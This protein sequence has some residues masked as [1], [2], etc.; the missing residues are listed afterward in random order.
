VRLGSRDTGRILAR[1]RQSVV[2]FA[3]GC[4]VDSAPPEAVQ[5]ST[6][7]AR[8]SRVLSASPTPGRRVAFS[9]DGA[10]LAAS[11]A[12]GSIE[13]WRIPEQRLARTLTDSGGVTAVAFSPDGQWLASASYDHA[14]RV[15]RVADGLLMQTL[16]GHEG[17]VWAVAVSPDGERIASSGEDRT[18]RLWRASD[19]ASLAVLRG[20]TLNV[21]SV[22]FTPD[23]AHIVSG[24]FDHSVRIWDARSGAL[25]QTLRGHDEAVVDVAVSPNAQLVASG[26]DDEAI[27]LWRLRDGALLRTLR[28]G[29]NHVWSVTFSRDGEW[30]ASAGRERGAFGSFWTELVGARF[31]SLKGGDGYSVRLWRVRDGALVQA[32]ATGS[33]VTSVAFSPD[34]QWLA[35]SNEDG[36]LKLWRLEHDAG[37]SDR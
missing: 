19:G 15:W 32:L 25:Q 30:L 29:T 16:R 36:A 28:G 9:Q 1:V 18:I 3:M 5:G 2:V 21:W 12:G 14:V 27:R 10:L 17:T 11:N 26:G 33:D 8:L 13:L 37:A 35:T 34:G 6:I 22:A 24:S 20:H 4:A 31:R 23:D 7:H